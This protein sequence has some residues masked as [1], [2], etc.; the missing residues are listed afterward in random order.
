MNEMGKLRLARNLIAF[1]R[2]NLRLGVRPVAYSEV[3]L[4]LWSGGEAR[5]LDL[6]P[7]EDIPAFP[8]EGQT[9]IGDLLSTLEGIC[10]T[11]NEAPR[12]LMLSDG[13]ISMTDL[14][15][16]KKWNDAHLVDMRVVAIGADASARQLERL[17]GKEN[18]YRAEDI[19]IAI[20]EWPCSENGPVEPPRSISDIAALAIGSNGV[21]GMKSP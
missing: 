16:W 11:S 20:S 6:D 9:S 7:G 5:F 19:A 15:V 18:V 12:L 10:A 4:V 1:I 2:E 21:L 8:A 14:D 17:C 13:G 3:R